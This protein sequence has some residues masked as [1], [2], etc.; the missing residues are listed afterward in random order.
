MARKTR[1]GNGTVSIMIGQRNSL[2]ITS[3]HRK[4]S[5]RSIITPLDLTVALT[6]R[7]LKHMKGEC[8]VTSIIRHF[9]KVVIASIG[10]CMT[11]IGLTKEEDAVQVARR[12]KSMIS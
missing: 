11:D 5:V 1:R 12:E 6:D 3:I 8:Q 10:H 9:S 2:F 4:E 7:R